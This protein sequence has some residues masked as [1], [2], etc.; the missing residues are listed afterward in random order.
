MAARPWAGGWPGLLAAPPQYKIPPEQFGARYRF[1]G[2]SG[3][4][5]PPA[6]MGAA[7]R[8]AQYRASEAFF[9]P[10][11]RRRL[12][13]RIPTACAASAPP[14][15]P[16]RAAAAQPFP[17]IPQSLLSHTLYP[18]LSYIC[19]SPK[20]ISLLDE[21]S[22]IGYCFIAFL[23][24]MPPSSRSAATLHL[25]FLPPHLSTFLLSFHASHQ[26]RAL[27]LRQCSPARPLPPAARRLLKEYMCQEANVFLWNFLSDGS[28]Q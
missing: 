12:P 16:P 1:L 14:Y 4:L 10:C 26:L 3:Q 2:V 18:T 11:L 20:F 7:Q 21:P 28:R 19:P 6:A 23:Q 5:V 27:S 17:L 22:L 24:S 13:A 25:H 9:P 15:L 8:D